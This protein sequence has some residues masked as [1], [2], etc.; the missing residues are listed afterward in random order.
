MK[1][2]TF[3]SCKPKW[4]VRLTPTQRNFCLCTMHANTA[5]MLVAMQRLCTM[6]RQF[7]SQEKAASASLLT[8][9]AG[10][11]VPGLVGTAPSLGGT[12]AATMVRG[13][14]ATGGGAPAAGSPAA[15]MARPGSGE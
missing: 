15:D 5:L 6:W 9:A 1:M 14:A 2:T 7:L 11:A 8:A 4:V 13:V 3:A 10:S 12:T